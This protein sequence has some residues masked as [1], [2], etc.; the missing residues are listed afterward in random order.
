MTTADDGNPPHSSDLL[1][2]AQGDAP[3]LI[4]PAGTQSTSSILLL[5]MVSSNG[6]LMRH[7]G[8]RGASRPGGPIRISQTRLDFKVSRL[9]CTPGIRE[10]VSSGERGTAL[11]DDECDRTHQRASVRLTCSPFLGPVIMGI[12]RSLIQ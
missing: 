11:H 4:R 7:P 9:A 8:R 3:F 1:R 2:L 5:V 12:T 6:R 10:T